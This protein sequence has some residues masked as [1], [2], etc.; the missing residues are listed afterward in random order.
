MKSGIATLI[1][2]QALMSALHAFAI[3][4]AGGLLLLFIALVLQKTVLERRRRDEEYAFERLRAHLVSDDDS[5]PELEPGHAAHRRALSRA[6]AHLDR[7]GS[8]VPAPAPTAV[9]EALVLH[10]QDDARHAHWGRRTAALE[11][12]GRLRRDSLWPFFID[13]ADREPDKR[14]FGAAITAAAKLCRSADHLRELAVLLVAKPALS[15]SFNESVL[16]RAIDTLLHRMPDEAGHDAVAGF[17][18]ALPKGHPLLAD[19][20]SAASRCKSRGVLA[21]AQRLCSDPR[22]TL[23]VRLTALRAIGRLQPD[24]PLLESALR[25]LAWEVRAVAAGHL[26]SPRAGAMEGLRNALRDR[27]FHVRRNA[28][29]ALADLGDGGRTVLREMMG[30]DDR[31]ARDASRAALGTEEAVRG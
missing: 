24:H 26:R 13:F 10:L 8:T 11:A 15:R 22:T 23:P 14:V 30:C 28:A 12:L 17:V 21:P 27:N 4:M 25:D 1:D 9:R 16:H 31:F 20:I 2:P 7:R 3:I 29:A 19:A 6:M 5:P 18:A